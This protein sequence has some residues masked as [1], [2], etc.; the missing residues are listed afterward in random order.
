LHI[1]GLLGK[2]DGQRLLERSRHRWEEN[3]KKDRKN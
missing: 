2:P 1:K 3:G